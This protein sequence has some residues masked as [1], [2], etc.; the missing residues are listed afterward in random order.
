[1]RYLKCN[2]TLSWRALHWHGSFHK[3]LQFTHTLNNFT[4]GFVEQ[5]LPLTIS[6]KRAYLGEMKSAL[7]LFLVFGFRFLKFDLHLSLRFLHSEILFENIRLFS[8]FY[9]LILK[10][11]QCIENICIM[12]RNL[13]FELKSVF[14]FI[15]TFLLITTF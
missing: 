8:I 6:R 10:M 2:F 7:L 3:S 11:H 14:F 5:S 1:M 4:T 15:T 9:H 13:K 12:H